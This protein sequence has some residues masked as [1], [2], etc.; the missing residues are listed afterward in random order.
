MRNKSNIS[1][2]NI[3]SLILQKLQ[4]ETLAERINSLWIK[5]I[6]STPGIMK[7]ILVLH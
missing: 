6:K 3:C 4:L 1:Y 2:F 7:N 5:H